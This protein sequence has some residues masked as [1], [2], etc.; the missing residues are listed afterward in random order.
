M[1]SVDWL[2]T[3]GEPNWCPGCG[4]FGL[5][6]SMKKAISELKSKPYN[7]VITSGIGCSGKLPHWMRVYCFNGLHGRALPLAMG[8]KLANHNL[9]VIAEGGD[10]DGCSEGTNHFVHFCRSNINITYIIH[11]NQIYGLT[12]G[13]ASPTSDEGFIT[14]TTP[15]GV[16]EKA[17]N[18]VLLALASGATFAA[19]GFAGD[20]DYLSKLYKKAIKHK[21]AALIDVLQPCVTFNHLNTY[22]W[23]QKRIYKLKKPLK[24]RSD[25]MKK[26][27]EW[28][29]RIPIGI[30]YQKREKTYEE[31]LPQLKKGAL[32]NQEAKTN[33]NKILKNFK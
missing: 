25:A 12:K 28:G 21:G 9:T 30:F 32:L 13:Q 18:P 19:R 6:N 7:T 26:A 29:D 14:K 27:M 24:A 5:W 11:N 17:V 3:K 33:I 31:R 20:I 22:K 4:N 23:Y 16:A 2:R 1:V 15:F 8:I 10:G